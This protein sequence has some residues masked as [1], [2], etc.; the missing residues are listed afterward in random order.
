[1]ALA[2]VTHISVTTIDIKYNLE[3]EKLLLFNYCIVAYV[4]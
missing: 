1:M 2:L 4:V 3:S